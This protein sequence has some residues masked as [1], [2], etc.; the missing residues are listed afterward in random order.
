[1]GPLKPLAAWAKAWWKKASARERGITVV[2]LG[3]ACIVALHLLTSRGYS[4]SMQWGPEKRLQ[5]SPGPAPD[6]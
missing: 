4:L 6:P 2:V 3:I 1:M 5:L